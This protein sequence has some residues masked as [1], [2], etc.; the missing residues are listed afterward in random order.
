MSR[1]VVVGAG[2]L[3]LATAHRL[4]TTRTPVTVLE[5]AAGGRPSDRPQLGVIHAG[6]YY[7]PGSE[8]PVPGR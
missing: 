7:P 1:Y 3:G 4:L 5:R 2:I 8:G 6:V